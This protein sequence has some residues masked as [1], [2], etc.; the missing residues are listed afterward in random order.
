MTISDTV[1]TVQINPAPHIRGHTLHH[2]VSQY[3][4]LIIVVSPLA[5]QIV[6]LIDTPW[7]DFLTNQ[8]T[9]NHWLKNINQLF[10]I[11][12]LFAHNTN[13]IT[14][15]HCE[16]WRT[17]LTLPPRAQ[18]KT[19]CSLVGAPN[20]ATRLKSPLLS[21]TAK[22]PRGK[23]SRVPVPMAGGEEYCVLPIE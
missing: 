7:Q 9:C 5:S 17:F 15:E 22:F 8:F 10:M 16:T 11:T 19:I 12:V 18:N 4:T 21:G 3:S 14:K 20:A 1:H 6:S 13:L 23:N 2:L